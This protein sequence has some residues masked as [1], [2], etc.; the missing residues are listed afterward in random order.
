MVYVSKLTSLGRRALTF[1]I[2]D[3][4]LTA[5]VIA[6][7]VVVSGFAAFYSVLTPY[8]D[9]VARGGI[10]LT[11]VSF[12]DALYFSVV[13]IS[14]LGYGDLHPI[15]FSKFLASLEVVFGLAYVGVVI[16]KITSRRLTYHVGRLF[17]TD[18]QRQLER[19][20]GEFER[21]SS[22][23]FTSMSLLGRAFQSTPGGGSAVDSS[24]ATL[25]F[26]ERLADVQTTSSRLADY[27]AFEVEQGKFFGLVPGDAVRR[28]GDNVDKTFFQLTQLI[29]SLSPEAKLIV[30]DRTIRQRISDTVASQKRICRLVQSN[31]SDDEIKNCYLQVVDTCERGL[32]GYFAVPLTGAAFDAPD[33]VLADASV[34]Q[35]PR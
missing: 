20:A 1:L 17:A 25:H 12:L 23:L 5:Y 29:I 2:E 28:V 3:L 4:S 26:R 9:G 6:L 10:A 21:H 7:L 15:G 31:S 18:A 35:S 24:A 16:A 8:G 14:T 11:S 30:L 34:P 22:E 13:T 32:A 33:Q 19:F 27:L